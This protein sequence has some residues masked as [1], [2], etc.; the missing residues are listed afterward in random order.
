MKEVK[1]MLIILQSDVS[2]VER[3]IDDA[4][5]RRIADGDMDA[6]RTLYDHVRGGVFGLA[7]SIVKNTHDADD[8]LQ[9]TFLK[10]Y[11]HAGEYKPQG[12]PLAWV[13]T[14]ARHLALDKLRQSSRTQPLDSGLAVDG[15]AITD[16][17]DRLL[18]EALLGTLPDE[19]KQILIL[20]AVSGMKHREIAGVLG[21]PLGTVLSKYHRAVKRLK[22][23][24]KEETDYDEQ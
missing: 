9:E 5:I 16:A 11:A 1:P 3:P 21:L 18:L 23:I 13:F 12:K 7:L 17:D 6:L 20:H 4:L 19:E 8:I 2:T 24:V 10:I 22:S 14:I 15:Q